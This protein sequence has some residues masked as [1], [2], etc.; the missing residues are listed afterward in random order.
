MRIGHLGL[1]GLLV[2]TLA[3]TAAANGRDPY[4]SSVQFRP[5]M[6]SH[7]MAGMTFGLIRSDDGGAT[8]QWYCEDAVGYGGTYDPDY[9]Y[10][11]TGALFA[12]TFDG[13]KVMRDGCTFAATPPG[14]T[15]VTRVERG[16]DGAIYFAASQDMVD[17]RI[18]KSTDDGV[19]F[20]TSMMPPGVGAG[21]WWQSIMVAPSAASRVYVSGY[22]T[23]LKCTASSSNPGTA[24]KVSTDCPGGTCEPRKEFL[25][26]KSTD[27][28]A[29]YITMDQADITPTSANSA[30]DI[31][32]VDP[33]DED[34]VY[35][36]VS[37]ETATTG[38]RIWKSVDAGANWTS[39]LSKSSNIGG[40]SFLVR[41]DGSCV[42]GT[43]DIGAW[44]S[45]YVTNQGCGA[46][47]IDLTTAPHIG[48]LYKNPATDE[49][50]ACTQNNASPQ[51]GITSDGFG[52]MK[53][54]DLAAW[55]GVL[56]FQDIQK[57]VVCDQSTV[58]KS[59]C[60]DKN[61][62]C[63]VSQTMISSTVIDCATEKQ[64]G[65]P[66]PEPAIDGT[67]VKKDPPPCGCG[68]NSAPQTLVTLLVGGL[69]LFRRRSPKKES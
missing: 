28:G 1:A 68:A 31:V 11:P 39:I 44:K 62:C 43:R 50:W 20:P 30:I 67:M 29:S 8:W 23:P 36:R 18:Y 57:P 37:Y 22:R 6:E 32:G 13:L 60:E 40:L 48:C 47:W 17:S 19:T 16:P 52:L 5:G 26:F 49:V 54:A 14:M 4:A 53:S 9:V 46:T 27:G 10:T 51:L 61:W 12:T 56:R 65:G 41:N 35:A 7:I 24:C 63:L 38:D 42:A 59:E 69:L 55:T 15:F 2:A 33:T 64:C 3:G 58:Q 21:D 45:A 25:L 66:Q 34:I